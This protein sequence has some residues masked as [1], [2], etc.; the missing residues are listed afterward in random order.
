[1]ASVK[2]PS[3]RDCNHEVPRKPCKTKGFWNRRH[4]CMPNHREDV[5]EYYYES[6]TLKHGVFFHFVIEGL[7]GPADVD[8]DGQV[9]LEELTIFAKRR[10][11]DYVRAEYDGVRQMPVLRGEVGGLPDL[12]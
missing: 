10:V 12:V 4:P 6:D 9:G 3:T 1:M 11:L 2:M 7:R 5:T 8:R